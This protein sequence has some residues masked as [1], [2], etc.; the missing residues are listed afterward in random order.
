MPSYFDA[1]ALHDLRSLGK[2]RHQALLLA[3]QTSWSI[4]Q[5]PRPHLPD[6]LWRN[7]CWCDDFLYR[8]L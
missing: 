6:F 3:T 8:F 4:V 2:D 5:K 1:R 7:D